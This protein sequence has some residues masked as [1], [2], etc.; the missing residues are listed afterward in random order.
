[1]RRLNILIVCLIVAI[2]LVLRLYD[3]ASKLDF[4]HDGDLYSWI[5][6]DIVIDRHIRLIG[7]ETSTPGIFIGPLFYYLL[8]PFFLLTNMDSI[9]VLGFAAILSILTMVSFYF[10]FAK[11]F[12]PSTGLIALTLQAFLPARVGLD[13]WVVPT[14]T[15]SLWEV[16]YFFTIFMIARGN[17][18]VFP[19][20]GF[21]I[22]LI[23]HINFSLAPALIAI[24][25][26]LFFSKKVP[27]LKQIGQGFLG[28]I[29]PSTPLLVFEIR[30][31]F[32]QMQ[33][34]INS[35][36][37]DQGGGSGVDKLSKVINYISG[38]ASDL[39]FYPKQLTNTQDLTFFLFLIALGFVLVIKKVMPASFYKI[40]IIWLVGV[41]GYFS[42]SSKIISEYYFSNLNII[43]LS[44]I[45]VAISY[46][47]KLSRFK[48][49]AISLAILMIVNGFTFAFIEEKG[50]NGGYVKRKAVADFITNDSMKKGYPC[51][52]VSYITTPGENVGFRYFFY[53]NNLVLNPLNG[54]IPVYTIVKP[55]G[56][57][58]VKADYHFGAIGVVIPKGVEVEKTRKS[59]SSQNSNLTD[60]MFGFTK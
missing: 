24:P 20:L 12:N 16:W 10:V 53:L 40:M 44:I 6:K 22:G 14:I 30:H 58:G 59:C 5:I 51:I 3:G 13:R 33:S 46:L 29:I 34:F 39:F 15:S 1:M 18:T 54:D 49:L 56:F 21:L 9:G 27:S 55:D 48:I 11:L 32:S 17:F 41:T 7:Q 52:F 47:I 4:G 38:G 35:F 23:W 28:F 50:N 19:L 25:T 57:A 43:F 60:P 2:G 8:I 42:I 45:I 26:A 37:V 36:S 31:G